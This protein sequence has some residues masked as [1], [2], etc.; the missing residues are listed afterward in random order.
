MGIPPVHPH[1]RVV[2][3]HGEFIPLLPVLGG[4]VEVEP[5]IRLVRDLVSGLIHVLVDRFHVFGKL[6][7]GFEKL[8]VFLNG[9]FMGIH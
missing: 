7:D 4:S 2:E 6:V 9:D 1:H 8:G 5:V 3:L